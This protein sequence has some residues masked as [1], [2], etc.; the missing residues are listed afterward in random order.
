MEKLVIFVESHVMLPRIIGFMLFIC[1]K[2]KIKGERSS[3]VIHDTQN[4][5]CR[6]KSKDDHLFLL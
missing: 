1:I 5:D 2:E 4:V 6:A 3:N